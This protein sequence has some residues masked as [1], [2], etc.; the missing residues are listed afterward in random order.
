MVKMPHWPK[1]FGRDYIDL[2]LTRIKSLLKKLGN[3]EKKIPPVIHVAGTNGKGSTIAF[4]KSILNSAGYK[5]HQY[6]SPHLLNFNERI[7]ISDNK[8]TDNQL[9]EVIEECRFNAK[10]LDL[11]F[12]EATTG[13][14]FLAFSKYHADIVLLET[15][16][17]GR[18]DATNIMENTLMSII[19]PI[20][21]DHM[22]YLGNNLLDIASE[23]AGIIKNYSKCII[24]WQETKVLNY[25]IDEC[26]KIG[27]EYIACQKD[28]NFKKIEQGFQFLDLVNDKIID[29]PMPN[30]I[31]IHQIINAST[32][33]CAAR[34][35]NGNFTINFNNLKQGIMSANWPSRMEKVQ[36]GTILSLLPKNSEIWLDGAHNELGAQMIAATI[37]TFIKMPTF[38]INGRTRNRDIKGFLLP[39]KDKVEY[40]LAVPVEWEPDSENPEKIKNIA[41]N[42]GIKSIEFESL[43]EALQLCNKL[44][45]GNSIRVIIC[46]SLYL[47]ADLKKLF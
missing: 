3:P 1:Q 35:L 21:Y 23:K 42:I 46:G 44:S 28:W 5:V 30:L 7:V 8:I 38:L 6:T 13:A 22:E 16:L 14:A 9:Y 32:A 12:F 29:F 47:T 39:F 36:N 37:D 41:H 26:K 11:T 45:K 19:T 25:L 4:L 27:S 10:G 2:G 43:K 33:I 31:G 18:Y 17:G 34:N 40:V 24:S 20:S 15:G